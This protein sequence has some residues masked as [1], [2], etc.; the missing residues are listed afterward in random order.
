MKHLFILIAI[1]FSFS[2]FSQRLCFIEA[3]GNEYRGEGR[4]VT[5]AKLRARVSCSRNHDPM[6]CD[7]D[8]AVCMSD[9]DPMSFYCEIEASNKLYHNFSFSKR[10]ATN[11]VISK[12]R[13]NHASIFCERDDVTCYN[14]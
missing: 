13:R 3:F 4:T 8:N 1:I 12:C 10:R 2:A 14:L 5:E 9:P 11:S 7:F 6:F